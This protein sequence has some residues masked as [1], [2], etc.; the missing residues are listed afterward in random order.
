MRAYALRLVSA[1]HK[2]SSCQKG[3]TEAVAFAVTHW[4][5]SSALVHTR[6]NDLL[7]LRQ[8]YTPAT[9]AMS[10]HGAGSAAAV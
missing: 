10:T 7:A 6:K 9:V 5:P 1:V 3:A 4:R 8:R 2:C